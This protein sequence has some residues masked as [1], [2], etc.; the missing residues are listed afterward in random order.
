M[1]HSR[2]N[3]RRDHW[4]PTTFVLLCCVGGV[5]SAR[6]TRRHTPLLVAKR[7][8]VGN[9]AAY[10]L[11]GT[12]R[13]LEL[14]TQKNA[15][16]FDKICQTVR[17]H[18]YDRNMHGVDWKHIT[19]LYRARLSTVSSKA[20]FEQL[21]NQM[22]CELHSSHTVFVSDAD[23][24]YYMLPSVIHGNM[25][26][27]AVEHIGIIGLRQDNDFIVSAVLNG[28]PAEKAGIRVGDRL[29]TADGLAFTT[30]G[31]FRHKAGKQVNI[32]LRRGD[33]ISDHT[34]HVVPI[35][36]N[37]LKSFLEATERSARILT[38]G[39]RKLGYI[40]LWTMANPAFRDALE[41][42]VETKLY[43][44]DGL[45]L[46]LRDG[47]GGS[48]NGYGDV[49]YRPDIL[50][51]QES[52]TEKPFSQH[53]SYKKPMVALI[54]GGTRSAKEYFSY[55]L[56]KSRRAIL[57]GSKTAGAFLG[58]GAFA[59]GEDGLLELA[60]VG[61][62]LDGNLLEGVG[63]V[64]DVEVTSQNPGGEGDRQFDRAQD[65]LLQEVERSGRLAN[66]TALEKPL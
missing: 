14:S 57:V 30:A 11:A 13:R 23:V 43:D 20:E 37:V 6:S 25:R 26:D 49:F 12:A 32:V 24:E 3:R 53:S 50:W 8:V 62:H 31:S 17:E 58:A 54:N 61:L 56:K 45:I 36:Q 16:N 19:D 4:I 65:V 1:I 51:L 40:H 5:T 15:E 66:H 21:M 10:N 18:F 63:I 55:E 42:L 2:F 35:K 59:I 39:G 46:D 33:T 48:P 47:Y 29:L 52:Q 22:L 28:G 64:P 41:T 38:I 60:V 7:A 27:Y 34:I 44:T 9:L